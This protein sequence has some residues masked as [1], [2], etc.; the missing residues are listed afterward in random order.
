MGYHGAIVA[1]LLVHDSTT[2]MP[3]NVQDDVGIISWNPG[4]ILGYHGTAI[5]SPWGCKGTAVGLL[6]DYHWTSIGRHGLPWLY[7]TV[8]EAP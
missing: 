8:M 5:G 4:T 3:R 7:D 1:L 2:G 6:W